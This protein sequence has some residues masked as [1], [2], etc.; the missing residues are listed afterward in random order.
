[1]GLKALAEKGGDIPPSLAKLKAIWATHYAVLSGTRRSSKRKSRANNYAT[2]WHL[3][4]DMYMPGSPEYDFCHEN[5]GRLHIISGE[6]H[7]KSLHTKARCP[8]AIRR[9]SCGNC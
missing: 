4:R 9:D 7:K 5:I 8:C 1:M 3:K 6:M 2:V